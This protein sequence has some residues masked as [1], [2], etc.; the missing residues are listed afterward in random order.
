MSAATIARALGG[1]RSAEG[2]LCRCPLP[3]HGKGS[4][5]RNPS[6]FVK[7]GD[8]APLFKCFAGCDARD[9]VGE[10]RGRGL[11]PQDGVEAPPI[12]AKPFIP[13]HKPD[14]EALALWQSASAIEANTAQATYIRS[15]GL[16]G[17][18]PPSLRATTILHLGRYPFPA[19]VAAVQAPARQIISI[20]CTL[21]DQRGERKAA[22]AVPRRTVGAIG[23]GA[24]RLAAATDVLGLAEGWEKALAAM[25]L[26]GVPCWASLG[27]GRMNRV[28]V[29]DNMQELHIF[30]DNDEP[31]RAGAERTAHEHRHRR[32]LLRF[33]PDGFKDW[34]D[35][36]RDHAARQRGAA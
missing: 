29:P 3:S 7:D 33:P 11:C 16:T 15:R 21:I 17:H 35:V 24:V 19:I 18:P 30:A 2:Y 5:D 1:H 8:K 32:V 36:T 12:E 20:Q 13:E 10:L 23:C 6:L 9:I 28:R 4:G 25:Q 26:F 34:D 14:P 22:V 31:G 27:A